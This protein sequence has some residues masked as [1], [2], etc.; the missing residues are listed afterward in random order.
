MTQ[1]CAVQIRLV[2]VPFSSQS[3]RQDDRV[4]SAS[5]AAFGTLAAGR[6]TFVGGIIMFGLGTAGSH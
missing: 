2:R 5:L 1:C 4:Y 3:H 6:I